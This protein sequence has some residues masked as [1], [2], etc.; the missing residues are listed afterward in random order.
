MLTL[1]CAVVSCGTA[2][3]ISAIKAAAR[4]AREQWSIPAWIRTVVVR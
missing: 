1:V 4:R 3:D 2:A